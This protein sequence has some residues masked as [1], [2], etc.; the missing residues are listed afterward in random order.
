MEEAAQF[1]FG[2]DPEPRK[3]IVLFDKPT[4]GTTVEKFKE[5]V[6]GLFKVSICLVILLWHDYFLLAYFSVAGENALLYEPCPSKCWK[7]NQYKNSLSQR[8]LSLKSEVTNNFFPYFLTG[9]SWYASCM[10]TA[11]VG[12]EKI[13]P[14]FC[15]FETCNNPR[16]EHNLKSVHVWEVCINWTIY[17]FLLPNATPEFYNMKSLCWYCVNTDLELYVLKFS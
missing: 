13:Y 10:S 1:D 5:M 3:E 6:Y 14:Y 7:N 8:C 17:F 9:G 16:D 15:Y 2:T 4:R 11:F 12:I